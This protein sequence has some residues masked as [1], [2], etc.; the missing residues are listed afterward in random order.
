VIIQNKDG[1]WE[2]YQAHE[3]PDGCIISYISGVSRGRE[4]LMLTKDF[5]NTFFDICVEKF[6]ITDIKIHDIVDD[7][8]ISTHVKRWIGPNA[9]IKTA[10]LET[11]QGAYS[12]EVWEYIK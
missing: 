3:L 4:C 12:I 10:C 7:N 6:A 5:K 9:N 1:E 8:G 2:E 11:V